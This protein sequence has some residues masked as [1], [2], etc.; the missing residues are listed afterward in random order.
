VSSAL[1]DTYWSAQLADANVFRLTSAVS[2]SL[3]FILSQSLHIF[4]LLF[5]SSIL[6]LSLSTNIS[7][8]KVRSSEIVQPNALSNIWSCI[9]TIFTVVPAIHVYQSPVLTAGSAVLLSCLTNP[10]SVVQ[11]FQVNV[12]HSSWLQDLR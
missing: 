8:C 1:A 3:N 4:Q 10:V 2:S 9:D 12:I 11:V 7:H 5:W 6:K